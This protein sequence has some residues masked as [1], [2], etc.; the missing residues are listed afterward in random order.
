MGPWRGGEAGELSTV[1]MSSLSSAWCSQLTAPEFLRWKSL[2]GLTW[3][4]VLK[5]NVHFH[6]L[7]PFILGGFEK[8]L[9]EVKV[10][11]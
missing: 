5:Q 2:A 7:C 6:L 10:W 4:C 3:S 11:G 1:E 8:G 9:M